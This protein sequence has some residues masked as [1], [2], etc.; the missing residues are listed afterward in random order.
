MWVAPL[1]ERRQQRARTPQRNLLQ[2]TQLDSDDSLSDLYE[3]TGVQA[4]PVRTQETECPVCLLKAKS[5]MQLTQHLHVF[6]L[7][8]KPYDCE[9]CDKCFNTKANKNTHFRTVHSALHFRCLRCTFSAISH[10]KICKHAHTHS[11]H[12]FKCDHCTTELSSK[13]ALVE[14][15]KRHMDTTVYP[16]VSCEKQ[17]SSALVC[18]IHFKG[19]HGDS[20]PC[21]KC[22]QRF[23]APIQRCRHLRKCP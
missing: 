4:H 16:C 6:H 3:D 10:F 5:Q 20:Y 12:K 22:G 23:D 14:H 18:Q 19:K 8:E 15:L 1:L 9:D 11:S 17:F 7:E 2:K 21:H 13:D